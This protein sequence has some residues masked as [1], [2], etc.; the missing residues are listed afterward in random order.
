MRPWLRIL[1]YSLLGFS[2]LLFCVVYSFYIPDIPIQKLNAKYGVKPTD[3]ISVEGMQ[4]HYRVEGPASDSIPLVLL[5]G[6]TSSLFTWNGWTDLLTDRHRVIRLDL[7]GFG[8]TGPHPQED[9]RVETYIKFIKSFLSKL[10]VKQCII[11]G[12]S[13]GGEIA[14]RYALENPTQV[15]K[16]ILIGAAGYPI[17][18]NDIPLSKI[19]LS[20]LMLRTPV[21]RELNMKFTSKEVIRT[22]L[23]YLY[24]EQ[25]KVTDQLV[26]LYLDMMC[27]EGNREALTERME[28]IAE[29]APWQSIPAI[30]TPTLILWGGLDRLIPVVYAGHFHKNLPNS[31]LQVFPGAG[32]MPMEEIPSESAEAVMKFI[33]K[34]VVEHFPQERTIHINTNN[35]FSSYIRH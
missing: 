22:S 35:K 3:Y 23:E 24:G 14:W 9:Y 28:S 25:E 21:M 6:T 19:P 2:L 17:K 20:Y 12:N 16:L 34:P 1:L 8:L 32:H 7:P 4:V 11:V 5:H 18:V 30:R 29:P 31:T 15:D 33:S 26:E 13:L 27:R 10:G